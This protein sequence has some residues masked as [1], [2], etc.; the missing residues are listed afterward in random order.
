[1]TIFSPLRKIISCTLKLIVF[2]SAFAGTLLSWYADKVEFMGGKRVFM[3]FTIQ[4]NIAIAIICATG[5]FLLLLNKE[6]SSV[7]NV[8]KF[9]GTIAITLTGVVFAFVLA[10]TIGDAAWNPQN[11]LTHLVVP[12]AAVIDFFVSC[13]DAGIQKKHIIYIIIPP[14]LYV[15]Y[16][17]I[18]FVKGWQFGDGINYPYFFLN[19]RSPAGAFGFSKE[20]PF[21]GT[22]WWIISLL[23]F[24]LLISFGYLMLADFIAKKIKKN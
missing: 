2:V 17:A 21:M 7:W 16:A 6:I 23:I 10:P 20:L 13:Y 9:T 22:V 15:I 19:W 12:V 3:Y 18:G 14:L 24:L 1:M 4:S 5:F 11:T 8:I